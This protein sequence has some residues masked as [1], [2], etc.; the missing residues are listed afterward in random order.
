[1]WVVVEALLLGGVFVEDA[2]VFGDADVDRVVVG[3]GVF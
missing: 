2:G 1:V 3:A